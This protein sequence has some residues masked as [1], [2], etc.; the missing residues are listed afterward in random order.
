MTAYFSSVL[1]THDPGAPK[2]RCR[3]FYQVVPSG[4]SENPIRR[5]HWSLEE[6]FHYS[7]KGRTEPCGCFH[8]E[9]CEWQCLLPGPTLALACWLCFQEVSRP[10]TILDDGVTETRSAQPWLPQWVWKDRG[11]NKEG[12][13]SWRKEIRIEHSQGATGFPRK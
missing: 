11:I 3:F 2:S 13:W 9:T 10:G 5:Y 6:L 7:G 12:H 4:L 1:H 8:Y